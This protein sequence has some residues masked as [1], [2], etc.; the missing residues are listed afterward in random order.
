MKNFLV[1]IF[2][3]MTPVV[4]LHLFLGTYAGGNTDSFYKR[5]TSPRQSNLILGNSRSAQ[6]ILPH[7]MKSFNGEPFYNYSFTIFDSPF[8][9]SYLSSVKNK[10]NPETKNGAFIV[11]VDPWSISVKKEKPENFEERNAMIGK[12]RFT[13]LNPNYEYLLK[14]Y[15]K[16]WFNLYLTRESKYKSKMFLND[17]GWLEIGITFPNK[18]EYEKNVQE[19]IKA[20][21]DYTK[22]FM[23]SEKRIDYLNQTISL[24]KNHGKVILIR[25]PQSEKIHEI[26]NAY[27]PT[28]N[29]K[30]QE[31]SRNQKIKFIDF[32]PLGSQFYYLDGNHLQKDSGKEFTK[33]LNDSLQIYM[34]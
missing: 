24:L 11:T 19:K 6:G 33:I 17:N 20:Y 22:E 30:M 25:M 4:L 10:L 12:T 2:L 18:E 13:N 3:W 27:S 32:T 14:N 16:S 31:I 5:F 9:D 15:N 34:K 1:K 26:E 8:G 29:Q 28:F 23:I 21:R 7:Y